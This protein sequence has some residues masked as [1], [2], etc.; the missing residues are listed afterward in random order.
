MTIP[1]GHFP[2]VQG[3]YMAHIFI[4]ALFFVFE[5]KRISVFFAAFRSLLSLQPPRLPRY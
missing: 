3:R 4:R 2:M 5:R 1:Y